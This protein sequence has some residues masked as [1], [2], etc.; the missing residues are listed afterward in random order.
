M[1]I[2]CREFYDD[3]RFVKIGWR[4]RSSDDSMQLLTHTHTHTRTLNLVYFRV[5]SIVDAVRQYA[6]AGAD[7]GISRGF[8]G[9]SA[10]S[11]YEELP[12]HTAQNVREDTGADTPGF[13]GDG[14]RSVR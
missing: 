13:R 1:L 11:H 7:E 12:V 14:R 4:G 2:V 6:P 3:Y 8:T 10:R 5:T 9:L